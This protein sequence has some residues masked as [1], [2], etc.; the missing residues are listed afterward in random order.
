[1]QAEKRSVAP[2][3]RQGYP[4]T[5]MVATMSRTYTLTEEQI[6]KITAD[7]YKEGL[8]KGIPPAGTYEEAEEVKKK[9]L[10]ELLGLTDP[11]KVE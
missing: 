3:Q 7:A 2:R 10:G 6:K 9:T 11:G 8:A 4:R 5:V 1:M